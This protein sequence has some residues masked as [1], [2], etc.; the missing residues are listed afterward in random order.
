HAFHSPLMEPVVEPFRELVARL[1]L[2]PPELPF[3]SNVT[4]TWIRPEEATDPGYWARHLR[5]PVRFAAGLSAIAG[6]EEAAAGWAIVE[7]GP[8]RT[9][10]TFARRHPAAVG[11]RAL[12]ATTREPRQAGSDRERALSAL[13]A[14]WVAGVEVDWR[15]VHRRADGG[16]ARRRVALPTYPFERRS[17]WL[18]GGPA[19]LGEGP[20]EASG[21]AAALAP[22]AAAGREPEPLSEVESTVAAAFGELLGVAGLGRADDF[23]ELG[24]S[25]LMA[26]QLGGRLR[27][28]LGVEL[29]SDF[30]LQAPTLGE[31]AVLIEARRAAA[32]AGEP[33]AASSCLVPLRR[34]GSRRPLF[35]VHQ[36][37][38]H[39]YSFRPL[40]QALPP[41]QPVYGLRSL[42]VE[43]GEEP[44][45]T[46]EA[47][48]AHYLERLREV[49]RRGPYRIGG[50]SM[51]GMVAFEMARRLCRA[52]EEVELLVLMDTPGGEQMPP[53]PEADWEITAA[54]FLGRVALAREELEGLGAEEQLRYA[55]GK[56]EREAGSAGF[57]L[58]DARRLAAVLR[59]NIAA[60]FA[61]RPEPYDGRLVYFRAREKRPGEPP[62][63]ETAWVELARDGA[64]IHLVPGTHAT[65]HEPPHVEVM[66]ARLER[67]LTGGMSPP[68]PSTTPRE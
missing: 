12:V 8:G 67:A 7:V 63:P 37:G 50:A 25:S 43:A 52:G 34:S 29:A 66:A 54:V 32:A 36:V 38:G 15:G 56:A 46:V 53:R 62:R 19:R 23:F 13:G 18:G 24:G 33:A 42:G 30:L 48:A 59:S 17:F 20:A 47:M 65:M 68:R 45:A 14:L 5:R 51:G 21:G 61:Y 2:R 49:Q 58:E 4:G 40:V 26:V 11:A 16:I 55:L 44:L 57:G 3:V 9:L 64:E 28:L 35:L 41:E 22:A 27:E 31:L 6:S 60:L 1:D 39:V 10:T